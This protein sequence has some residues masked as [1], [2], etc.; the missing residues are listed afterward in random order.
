M[1]K[2]KFR[3]GRYATALNKEQKGSTTIEFVFVFLIILTLTLGTVEFCSAVYTYTTL[4]DAANEGLRY[5]IVNSSN[6]AQAKVVAK[7]VAAHSFHN[8]SA[9]TVNV[10]CTPSCAAGSTAKVQV[11]Y[12]YLPYVS[13]IMPSPPTMHAYAEGLLVN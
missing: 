5:L 6:S 11:S 10:T 13:W 7:A 2:P 4:S 8:T 9:I 12:A 1:L 3:F